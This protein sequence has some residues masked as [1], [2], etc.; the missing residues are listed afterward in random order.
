MKNQSTIMPV[1]ACLVISAINTPAQQNQRRNRGESFYQCQNSNTAGPGDIWVSVR[2]VGHIWDDDPISMDSASQETE[3]GTNARRWV[4]NIRAF[5]EIYLQGGITEFLSAHAS[6]RFLSYGF[7]PG[8]FSGGVK[9][10]LPNNLELRL[11]GIGLSIDYRYQTRETGPSLGGYTGFMPEGFVVK[12]HNL[13]TVFVYELDLL[14]RFS[15]LPLRLLTNVGLRQP[16]SK[17]YNLR[18]LLINLCV[19]YSGYGFDFFAQYNLESFNNIFGSLPIEDQSKK[20]LVWF[21]ENPMYFT[22]GGNVRYDN[23]ITLS[24]AVPILLSVNNGSRMRWEDQ[25]ALNRQDTN[26]PFTYEIKRGI[27][28]PFD[29]WFA[30][31]K[32]VGTLSFPIRFKM[33]GAEMMRNYLLLKNRKQAKKIDI[34]NRLHLQEEPTPSDEIKEQDDAKRRLEEIKKKRETLTK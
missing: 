14:P 4:S 26:S 20:F 11:N 30:K 25:V 7:I 33:S 10:T 27:L 16:L 19:V 24:L 17:R 28:D 31:W 13:E 23:G 15:F 1:L 5:P 12:G 29:P 8:W 9:M 6:S 18:Q 32:I 3:G 34:D 21:S 2:G 22:L